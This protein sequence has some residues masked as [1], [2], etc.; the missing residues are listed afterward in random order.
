MTGYNEPTIELLFKFSEIFVIAKDTGLIDI[1]RVSG[2]VYRSIVE[3]EY[4]RTIKIKLPHAY[5]K[6]VQ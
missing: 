4:V 2:K 3:Y 6:S 1:E 5:I